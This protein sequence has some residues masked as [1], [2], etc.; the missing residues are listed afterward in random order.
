MDLGATAH[1]CPFTSFDA[2]WDE[3]E[4]PSGH[5]DAQAPQT[6]L[7]VTRPRAS[8]RRPGVIDRLHL[9]FGVSFLNN[10]YDYPLDA[11]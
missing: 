7:M 5:H 2:R 10:G 1:K 4:D 9:V 8:F 3:D 6:M 11:S